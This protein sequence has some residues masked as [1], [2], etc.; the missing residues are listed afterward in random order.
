MMPVFDSHVTVDQ[1]FLPSVTFGELVEFR[2]LLYIYGDGVN[3]VSI[4]RAS[5]DTVRSA[6]AILISLCTLTN[7]DLYLA[8]STAFL[9][10]AAPYKR[11]GSIPHV[12]IVFRA[13]CFS[14]QLS[15]A[16]VDSAT[17]NFVHSS[18]M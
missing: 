17:I 14:P 6:F 10:T 3:P 15:F 9:Q 13:A 18:A 12:Y 1:Y 7:F 4:Q 2:C 16:D 5:F 8:L 11:R